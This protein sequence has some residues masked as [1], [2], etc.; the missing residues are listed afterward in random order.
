MPGKGCMPCAST[1]RPACSSCCEAGT[2][3]LGSD[4]SYMK[5][6]CVSVCARG[7]G[8]RSAAPR[9]ATSCSP[10]SPRSGQVPAS[11]GS[12]GMDLQVAGAVVVRVSSR[13]RDRGASSRFK[14]VFFTMTAGPESPPP[15]AAPTGAVPEALPAPA[16]CSSASR[17]RRWSSASAFASASTGI[18][19]PTLTLKNS[20]PPASR[21]PSK[22]TSSR[23]TASSRSGRLN[24]MRAPG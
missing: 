2:Q 19:T 24:A 15:R 9:S 12:S 14:K 10:S 22:L 4:T 7:T 8:G 17:K 23:S 6:S 3:V 18:L 11:S 21:L 5:P 1:G 20:A 16:S 13:A